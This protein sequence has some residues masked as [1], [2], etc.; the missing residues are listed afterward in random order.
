MFRK[1]VFIF[2]IL[3]LLALLSGGYYFSKMDAEMNKQLQLEKTES[4][5]FAPGSS[6]RTLANQLVDK[7]LLTEK[8]TF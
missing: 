5:V 7:R 3:F 2:A 6:I 4:I 8:I 1:I